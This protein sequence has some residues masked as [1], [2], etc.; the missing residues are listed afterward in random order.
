MHAVGC[1]KEREK[2]EAERVKKLRERA[3]ARW[4]SLVADPAAPLSVDDRSDAMANRA[5]R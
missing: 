1:A 5:R 3:V 4:Q 2:D